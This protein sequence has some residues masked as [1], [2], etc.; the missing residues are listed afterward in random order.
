VSEIEIGNRAARRLVIEA[1][2]LGAERQSP[3][4]R[5]ILATVDRLLWLQLDPTSAVARSHHLVLWSRLGRYDPT[6]VARLI[7]RDHRLF[8]WRAFVYPTRDLPFYRLA[9]KSRSI[10]YAHLRRR[11]TFMRANPSLR[12]QVLLRLRREGPLPTSAFDGRD[13]V[14][15]HSPGWTNERNASQMLEFLSARGRVLVAGRVGQERL[16]DLTERCVPAKALVSSETPA[17]L[18]RRATIRSLRALGLATAPQIQNM[19]PLALRGSVT[20]TIGALE[21]SGEFVPARVVS[22]DGALK[23]RWYVHADDA[24]RIRD[25]ERSWSGRTTLLSPFDTLVRD[26]LRAEA[27]FGMRYRIEIYVPRTERRYGYFAMPILHEDELIG[28][29]DPRVDRESETLVVN[30]VHLEPGVRR[31]RATG[32]AIAKALDDLAEFTGMSRVSV[33]AGAALPGLRSSRG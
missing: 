10:K 8:E 2:L 12:R 4:R 5:G 19:L 11:A 27:L 29:I 6:D 13:A 24:E 21:R 26:R 17:T 20:K 3:D 15:W 30:A 1:Q 16:W 31:E 18:V 25:F 22:K 32:R 33:P 23:G 28:R 9:M 7:Y 14:S